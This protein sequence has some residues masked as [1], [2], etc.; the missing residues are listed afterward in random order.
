MSRNSAIHLLTPDAPDELGWV[1][2]GDWFKSLVPENATWYRCCIGLSAE[3]PE[4]HI[5]VGWQ[6]A[7]RRYWQVKQA[8]SWFEIRSGR[9]E[10]ITSQWETYPLRRVVAILR[11][12]DALPAAQD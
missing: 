4:P 3:E 1:S 11:T 7:Q 5:Y 2:W 8:P 12:V 6:T 9:T 10:I